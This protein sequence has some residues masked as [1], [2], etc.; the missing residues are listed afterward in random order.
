MSDS[1][2]SSL[3]HLATWPIVALLFI[4]FIMCAQG[5]EWR[6][7]ILGYDNRALDGRFWYSPDDACNFLRNIGE[8][9]RRL[10][11]VTELTL[12][13]LFPLVYGTLFAALIIHVYA[14]ESGRFLVLVP[15]LTVVFDILENI[16]TAYLAWQFDDR[17]SPVARGA[18]ILTATKSGLFILSLTLIVI[19]S[20]IT[21]WRMYRPPA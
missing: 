3:E 18:A 13:V 7:K 14:R 20:L 19:G 2:H 5:F 10:Y 17:T 11:A 8:N 9:G 6:R 16:I 12:D 1:F 15:L 21:A 4:V